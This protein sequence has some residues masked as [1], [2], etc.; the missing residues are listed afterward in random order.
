MQSREGNQNCRTT[1]R[2]VCLWRPSWS[3]FQNMCTK[4]ERANG[5]LQNK[6]RAQKKKA[7]EPIERERERER[8]SR[9]WN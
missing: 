6:I 9:N 7:P 3:S 8:E 4:R 1:T 2:G 5:N